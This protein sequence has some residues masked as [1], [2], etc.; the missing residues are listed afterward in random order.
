MKEWKISIRGSIKRNKDNDAGYP[1]IR[2]N[3]YN[4]TV[5]VIET[6]EDFV[7]M[8]VGDAETILRNIKFLY[9]NNSGIENIVVGRRVGEKLYFNEN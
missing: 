3:W 5:K 7:A 9:D 4:G 2:L 8:L 1:K 6:D